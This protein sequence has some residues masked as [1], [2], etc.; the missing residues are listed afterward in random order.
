MEKRSKVYKVKA[1]TEFGRLLAV[2]GSKTNLVYI[3]IKNTMIKTPFIKLYELKNPLILKGVSKLIGI[4][5]LN[6][7]VVIEDSIGKGV[8]LDLSEIDDI[9][10]SKFITLEVPGPPELLTLGPSRSPEPENRLLEPVFRF[11]EEPIKLVDFL[12]LDEIQ[13]NLIISFCY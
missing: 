2:L 8:L 4:R 7:V 1:R 11:S 13:L 3:P 12:N 9:G 5:P 10:S 6:D